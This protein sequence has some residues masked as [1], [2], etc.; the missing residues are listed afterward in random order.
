M[1]S[2]SSL[3]GSEGLDIRNFLK[4][5]NSRVLASPQGQTG[6]GS[7]LPRL[8]GK[9]AKYLLE[10]VRNRFHKKISSIFRTK[11]IS[12]GSLGVDK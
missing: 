6:G 11:R 1:F 9:K 8:E 7:S 2:R 5:L 4:Y 3:L 10:V 12:K